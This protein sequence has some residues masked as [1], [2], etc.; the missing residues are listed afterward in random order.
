MVPSL[1][2]TTCRAG[3]GSG[4]VRRSLAVRPFSR[5]SAPDRLVPSATPKTPAEDSATDRAALLTETLPVT[6]PLAESMAN[7]PVLRFPARAHMIPF[8]WG[9]AAASMLFGTRTMRCGTVPATGLEPADVPLPPQPAIAPADMSAMNA[10][11]RR[12]AHVM[13]CFLPGR[14]PVHAPRAGRARRLLRGERDQA[15]VRTPL[16]GSGEP[17][18]TRNA[19]ART[20]ASAL[21]W[22]LAAAD[23]PVPAR[24][25][26]R[27]KTNP[28]GLR[29]AK[30]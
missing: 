19:S 30:S 11:A 21:G 3:A 9:S 22:G 27:V 1:P 4:T 7:R 23:A 13:A 24:A 6:W 16:P 2:A 18:G 28:A 17:A 20:A 10:V 14:V 5:A 8:G 26:F 25:A 12:V 29:T 15:D